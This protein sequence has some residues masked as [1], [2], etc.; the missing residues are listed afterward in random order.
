MS[1]SWPIWHK[2]TACNYVSGKSW[3]SKNTAEVT[4]YCGTSAKNSHELV[5]HTTT[6]RTEGEYT[7][8]RFGYTLPLDDGQPGDLQLVATRYMHTKTREMMPVGWA[9][10]KVAA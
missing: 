10:E 4:V 3:G 9:P 5:S 1:Y 7:I 6:R 8:Y 2:V